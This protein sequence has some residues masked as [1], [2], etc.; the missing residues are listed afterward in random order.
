M[1]RAFFERP[2]SEMLRRIAA[3]SIALLAFSAAAQEEWKAPHVQGAKE[4]KVLKFYPESSVDEF[5]VIDFDAVEMYVGVNKSGEP[6]MQSVEGKVT[7][8]HS[9]H[10]PGTSAL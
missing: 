1:M 9:N 7:K 2:C 8:Y 10:K 6:I 5:Q 4:H 3:A